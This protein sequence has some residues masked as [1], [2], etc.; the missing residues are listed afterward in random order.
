[1]PSWR[2]FW[3][4][5]RAKAASSPPSASAS[6][7]AASLAERVTS[8]IMA[9]RTLTVPPGGMPILVG[10]ALSALIDTGSAVAE[11][12][13]ARIEGREGEVD[14]HQLGERRRMAQ[15]VG[16]IG[17]QFPAAGRIDDEVGSPW[18]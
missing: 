6:T 9:S 12:Q 3:V 2:A 14:R 1:M 15:L 18:P 11:R 7:T 10:G 5:R 17:G 16:L 8:A 13:P 4:I